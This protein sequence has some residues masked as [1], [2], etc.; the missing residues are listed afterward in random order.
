MT[1]LKHIDKSV[2]YTGE[3]TNLWMSVTPSA[4]K[5]MPYD[6]LYI[7]VVTPDPQWSAIFNADVGTAGVTQESAVLSGYVVDIDGNIEIPY[8]GRI[9]VAGKT[10]SE[11]KTELDSIFKNYVTD[12]ALTVRLVNNNIS[13]L[14]E[15]NTPGRYM[16]T[17]DRINIFEA[18]SMAGD[19]SYYSNRQKVQLIRPTPYGP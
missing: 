5:I 12:A 19:M 16:L 2:E 6:N 1:Y 13:I 3:E 9:N 8:V 4:Y 18:L 11:I 17:K 14:G 10:L 15:V 7:R